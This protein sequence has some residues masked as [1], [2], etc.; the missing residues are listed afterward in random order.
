MCLLFTHRGAN[1]RRRSF[2]RTI[3]LSAATA[4]TG[5]CRWRPV[6]AA[7]RKLLTTTGF[8]DFIDGTVADGGANTYVAADGTIRLINLWDLNG[9]GNIDV[10]FPSTHDNNEKVNLFIYWGKGGFS[11]ERRTELPTNGAKAIAIADLDHNGYC[12]LIVANNANETRTD[13]N[14]YIYWGSETG[15]ESRRRTE[16]PTQAAEAV[17]VSDLNGDGFPEII[18]ANG[19]FTYHSV[20]DHFNQSYVYWGSREGYS[21]ERR[22]ALRTV[23][24]RDVKVADLNRDGYLEIVFANQG[25]TSGES[26]ALIYWGNSNGN[27][28]EARSTLLPGEFSSAVALADLN[29][30]GYTDIVLAN[31]FRLR[32]RDLGI[33]NMVDSMAISSYIYWGSPQGYSVERRTELPTV[34]ASSV[35][36]GDLDRDGRPDLVF[37]NDGGG[38]SYIYWNSVDGFH[39]DRRTALPTLHASKCAIDDL[40][41]DGYSDLIFANNNDGKSHKTVSYIYWGGREGFSPARRTELPTLGAAAIGIADLR[42]EGSKDLVFINKED[43]TAGGPTDTYIYWGSAE[44]TFSADRRQ[45]LPTYG[46]YSYSAADINNDG[47]VDLFIP[48]T[49]R[50]TIYWG[51]PQGYSQANKTVVAPVTAF[52]GVIADF[53]RDG[54]LDLV[55]GEWSPGGDEA[56]L[57]YGGPAGFSADNRFVFKIGNVR[58]PAVADLNRD[59][60][61]DVIFPTTTGQL[62]IYWNG[63][64]GFDNARKTILPCRAAVAVKI[65][66]LNADGYLDIIVANLYDPNP[67][68]G[69][70]SAFGGSPEG[71]TYIYWGSAQGYSESRRLVLP[72]MGTHNVAVADLNGD[73]LLDLVLSCYHAGSTRNHPS[74][75]YW[76]SPTGFNAER[77]TLLPTNSAA[78]ILIAD[79]NRDGY[80]DILFACHEKDENHRTDS[81]LYWGG[82]GGYSVGR[83]TTIPGVGVHMLTT[84]DIG[85]V[86]DRIDRYDYVSRPLNGGPGAHFERIDW[87][88]DTPFQTGI[89]FQVRTAPTRDGLAL[90]QWQGPSGPKSFYRE[91]GSRLSGLSANARWIQYKASLISPGSANSPVLRS[92]SIVYEPGGAL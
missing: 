57:Y 80:K 11:S 43:G 60:W 67:P 89:E 10:V 91:P 58:F 87:K 28:S 86:Y 6:R 88:G 48:E 66:D 20:E 46:P 12:D 19:G 29:G 69:S 2:L 33:Y 53:N 74:Y 44:G 71:D 68:A 70:M 8:L 85:N 24:A 75:I 59:N 32:G 73:G 54:Y 49:G 81:F 52:S 34:G 72:S 15:F 40:N 21:K 22:S 64:Q 41:G 83:R 78:G 37:A 13:L 76:N 50:Q 31:K 36:V 45:V 77:V 51:G 38:A 82:P 55:L 14:S 16:L 42:R 17:T 90:S 35:A 30:D 39:P 62:V 9:D 92:V 5:L 27:Y 84:V 79:F 61:P 1:L 65:A 4:I 56:C 25:N 23:N 7:A 26:G 63:P 3:S 47:Y 18:F